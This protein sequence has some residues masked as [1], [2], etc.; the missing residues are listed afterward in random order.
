M[1]FITQKI[2]QHLIFIT[3]HVSKNYANL[4]MCICVEGIMQQ[5]ANSLHASEGHFKNALIIIIVIII[6]VLLKY[7][8]NVY[9]FAFGEE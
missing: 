4:F 8:Q 5:L 7:L 1:S 2:N 9:R 3:L 6:N